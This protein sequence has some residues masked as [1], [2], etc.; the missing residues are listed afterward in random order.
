MSVA[1]LT[2]TVE[3]RVSGEEQQWRRVRADRLPTRSRRW[4]RHPWWTV[5][6]VV[7]VLVVAVCLVAQV[8]NPLYHLFFPPQGRRWLGERLPELRNPCAGE[9]QAPCT[10]LAQF[11]SPLIGAALGLALFYVLSKQRVHRW[12]N[13]RARAS[14]T[15]LVATADPSVD[16]VVGRDELCEVLIE[17]IR[18]PQVR[19]PVVLVGGVGSGKTAI[20]VELTRQL[21]RRGIVPVPVRMRD[22]RLAEDLT[23]EE[24]A[25]RR[26]QELVDA[27]LF[28]DGS[29]T[30]IWRHLRMSNRI[31]VLADGLH[32]PFGRDEEQREENVLREAISQAAEARLPL[33]VTSRP[34]DP[35]RGM[36][37]ILVGLE[38]LGEGAA[39][40][41]GLDGTPGAAPSSWARI[42]ALIKAADV[43][44]SP[45]FL[46][47][48]RA[49][50][51]SDRL[52]RLSRAEAGGV[53]RPMDRYEARWQLLDAWRTAL[54]DGTLKRDVSRSRD[55]RAITLEVLSAFACLAL[56]R[57]TSHLEYQE[58]TRGHD[59][60]H[61]AILG[62]LHDGLGNRVRTNLLDHITHAFVEGAEWAVV[63]V[64]RTEAQ[65]LH[66]VVQAYLGMR[67]LTD[68]KLLGRLLGSLITSR[69][70]PE[71]LIALTLLSRHL[72]AQR[73]DRPPLAE[74]L[75]LAPR[76]E[77]VARLVRH[78]RE[79]AR[80]EKDLCWRFELYAAAVESDTSARRPVHADLL[81]EIAEQWED[82]GIGHVPN[83]PANQARLQLV[84]RIGDA[85]RLIVDR[86]RTCRTERGVRAD[87]AGPEPN[88]A[89]FFRL[90][91]REGSYRVRLAAAR[92]IGLGG[93]EAVRGLRQVGGLG[94]EEMPRSTTA[95]RRSEHLTYWEQQLRGWI[96]PL[97]YQSAHQDTEET[98]LGPT[99]EI[100][101][102]GGD[103]RKW[104][105]ALEAYH[106]ARP[107][108]Y[109]PITSEIAF[110]QGFRLAANIRRP[111]VG[112]T[113]SDRSFLVEKAERTLAHSRFWYS[114]LVLLQALT[115]FSL[116]VD[117]AEP[118]PRREHGANPYGLVRH[119][120]R[121][122]GQAVR[123]RPPGPPHP[124][125]L[126]AGRLCVRA[127]LSRRPER[128]C[129][130]DERETSSRVGSSST[131]AEV[132]REQSLWIPDSSGWSVLT[133]H[134]QRLLADVM[135]LLNLADRG[136]LLIDRE[137]RLTRADRA[138]LP[139][140]L[141][142]D[143]RPLRP[144]RTLESSESCSPGATCLDDCPFRL[145]P[146][147]A[148]GEPQPHELDQN[149][150]ARQADLT[151]PRYLLSAR[152]PW[153][154]TSRSQLRQF[155]RRM[156]ER[157]LP[158]W[159]R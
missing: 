118:L 141:T 139:P 5:L 76:E 117:P 106:P 99:P 88:Y 48:I 21:A 84:R 10:T 149:F 120:L 143:R 113:P 136:D 133:P 67:Y 80:S 6:A 47:V 49:L 156:S 40:E 85:A 112:R 109:F 131:V 119:W 20:I 105:R 18:D 130:I 103:L 65:F 124:F 2:R 3:T 98:P 96:L 35:L 152:S 94:P 158:E 60:E 77:P 45:F 126:E 17:R 23:F 129:W 28:S 110:A 33:I 95:D 37:A 14:A 22:A 56:V 26:F 74:R 92:E 43:T 34:Y 36:R 108:H 121:I 73:S 29:G 51:R 4:P 87:R 114:Q 38:P 31:A 42:V 46:T 159:R 8:L 75:P 13:R 147:P 32:E 100:T 101:Q 55:D 25:R 7:V 157:Q 30:R 68:P 146:L 128:Y 86:A 140:C 116:P 155:W 137:D 111:L 122:A 104:L 90:A 134:A 44:D 83:R 58:M 61:R 27:Q 135:L 19:S 151:S 150:C 145:C 125:L 79:Q 102:V 148:E 54:L 69:R 24:L 142:S 93:R 107:E 153:Q 97:L 89:A 127:L 66:G 57:G 15:A 63:D 39:L 52:P 82:A 9:R 72:A 91:G 71:A 53:V 64:R 59:A 138:D 70:N 154:N 132:R 81:R 62:R 16:R 11:F 144:D 12:Y 50:H 78:L 115:L 1:K 123:G 41:H